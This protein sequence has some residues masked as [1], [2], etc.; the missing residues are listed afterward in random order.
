MT[1]MKGLSTPDLL[2]GR[3][4]WENCTTESETCL[5]KAFWGSHTVDDNAAAILHIRDENVKTP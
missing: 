2:I 5:L 1:V 3:T 4:S